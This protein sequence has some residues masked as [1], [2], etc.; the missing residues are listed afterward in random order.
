MRTGLRNKLLEIAEL[1]DCYEPTVPTKDT[2]KPYAVTLYSQDSKTGGLEGLSRDIEVWLYMDVS[3][4]GNIDSLKEKVID[5]LHFKSFEDPS[6]GRS[7]TARFNST[8]T[9]DS[10]DTDWDAIYVGLS[11]SVMAL[12]SQETSD[13]WEDAVTSFIVPTAPNMAIYKGGWSSGFQVPSVLVRT[14]SSDISAL[15]MHL[16][17]EVRTLKVHVLS[18]SKEE[19]VRTIESIASAL[20]HAIKILYDVEDRRFLTVE[21]VN[22]DLQQDALMSGQITVTMSRLKSPSQNY[23]FI[24]FIEGKRIN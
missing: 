1:K 5:K 2:P 8:L 3:R 14:T 11:F 18:L 17:R 16:G 12:K 13:S 23:D 24:N 7:Y 10:V 19:E 22:V 6:T 21:E 4:F 15:N 9:E 20:L